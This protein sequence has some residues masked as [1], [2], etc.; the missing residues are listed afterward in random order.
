MDQDDTASTPIKPIVTRQSA[1]EAG[2]KR[3]FTGT[4]C[5]HGHICERYVADGKCIECCQEKTRK[6]YADNTEAALQNKQRY[7]AENKE[8]LNQDTRL[9]HKLN[10]ARD[11]ETTAIWKANNQERH[12]TWL[13]EWNA[14]RRATAAGNLNVRIS[15]MVRNSLRNVGGKGGRSW[16]SLVD[17]TPDQLR[18]HLERQFLK[19]MS[20]DNRHLW[21]VDHIL[22]LA[23][24][25]FTSAEDAEFKAAWALTN[26]RPLWAVKNMT[27]GAKR[28]L[29]L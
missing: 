17:Y 24:F 12:L 19:G 22:P 16:K 21:H 6:W 26:L 14:K 13:R 11:R 4:P 25:T 18:T 3:F 28:E 23:S 9:R 15:C 5:I 20:W 7:Y 8:K 10:A 2:I 1:K 27:K 29:L